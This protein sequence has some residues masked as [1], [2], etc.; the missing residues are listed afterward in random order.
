MSA[1]DELK[2]KAWTPLITTIMYMNKY[3]SKAN[4]K[5]AD[6][7]AAELAALTAERDALRAFAD[8]YGNHLMNCANPFRRDCPCGF[9]QARAARRGDDTP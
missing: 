2:N 4:Q 3:G 8:R 1:L 5:T 7:A 6:K 9:N